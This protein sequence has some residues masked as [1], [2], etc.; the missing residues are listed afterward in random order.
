MSAR[1]EGVDQLSHLPHAEIVEHLHALVV[2]EIRETLALSPDDEVPPRASFVDELGL[3]SLRL[4]EIK[5]RLEEQLGCEISA[6][7]VFNRPTV[8]DLVAYLMDLLGLGAAAPA[9][10]RRNRTPSPER[11]TKSMV[12]DM[13]GEIYRS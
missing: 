10:P 2:G 8:D 9:A 12:N 3:S 7:A 1:A 4:M 6:N 5:R 13:L 11:G